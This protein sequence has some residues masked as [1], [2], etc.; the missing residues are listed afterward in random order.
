M[1]MVAYRGGCKVAWETYD[2]EAEALAA[3]EKAKVEAERKAKLGYD[4]GY[5]SPGQ[6]SHVP[7]HAEYGE[8]WIVTLP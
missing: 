7:N 2:D 4:F 3:S 1:T 5:Q 6:I 8:V